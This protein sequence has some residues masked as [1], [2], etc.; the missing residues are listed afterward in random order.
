MKIIISE[1][2]PD[3]YGRIMKIL[4]D[5]KITQGPQ[6]VNA[7]LFRHKNIKKFIVERQKLEIHQFDEY[8]KPLQYK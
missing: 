3:Y 4:N 2:D 1:T 7:T 8:C 6:A 5:I